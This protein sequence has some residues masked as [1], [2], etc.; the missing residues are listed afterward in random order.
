MRK[1]PERRVELNMR[2]FVVLLIYTFTISWKSVFS[3]ACSKNV[4]AHFD[5]VQVFKQL[6]MTYNAD[7]VERLYVNK[8]P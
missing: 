3:N 8:S 5:N 6:R 4:Q 1:H 7:Q 2:S